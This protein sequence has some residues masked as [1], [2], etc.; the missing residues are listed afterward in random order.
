[1]YPAGVLAE[2]IRAL[3]CPV[4]RAEVIL[5]GHAI[6]CPLG[7]SIDLGRQGHASMLGGRP[8]RA[9]G[10][11]AAMIAARADF[12]AGGHFAPL[13]GALA[14]LAAAHAAPQGLL[15]EVGAGTAY[16]LAAVLDRL[17][18]RAG[19]AIDLSPHAARRAARAHER[20]AAIVADATSHLPLADGSAALIL[21]VFAPR[22]AAELAR[23]L[24][25]RG[26]LL[27]VTPT[28]RHLAE[29]TGRLGL[30]SVDAAKEERLERTLGATFHRIESRPLTWPL[31]LDHAA[32]TDLVAMGPS[33]HHVATEDLATRLAGLPAIL[34]ATAEV[35]LDLLVRR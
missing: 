6:R 13:A 33:A 29:L 16:Y 23:L 12:L 4:C 7:H 5:A 27:V 8:P 22:N 10:D 21:D 32:A 30:L 15:V 34:E 1:V 26:A 25:P 18:G 19:L 14:E 3:R 31:R 24:D 2:V 17:P 35:R 28:P 9:T 11:T 20:A